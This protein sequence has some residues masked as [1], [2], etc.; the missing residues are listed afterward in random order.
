MNLFRTGTSGLARV[1]AVS[2]CS[3]L[4]AV[5]PA[6]AAI[7]A[8]QQDG[9]MTMQ[10]VI[11][12]NLKAGESKKVLSGW[13]KYTVRYGARTEQAGGRYTCYANG[14]K[15]SSG[16]LPAEFSHTVVGYGSCFL[17]SPVATSYRITSVS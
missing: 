14:I 17:S 15:V 2:V 9:E 13:G 10:K 7:A 8:P 11:T 6:G 12:G 1:T 3:A 5:V 4:L 16:A